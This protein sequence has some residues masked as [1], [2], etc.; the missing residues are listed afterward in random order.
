MT[1]FEAV[2]LGVIQGL[3]E[4][5]PISS[6]AHLLVLSRIF[7][8]SDPGAAFTAVSQI[9]TEMAV[10]IYFRHDIARILSAWGR[11]LVHP[12]MRSNHD[13]K[14]GWYVIL[15]TIPIVILGLLF[16]EQIET[17]ARNLWLTAGMLAVFGILLGIADKWG[18]KI[19]G[20]DA[21]RTRDAVALGIAQAAALI[22]GVS[23]SGATITVGLALG[24]TREAATRYAFLLAIP[25]V[26][27]SG[28]YEAT[29]IG[30]DSNVAWG[31][32]LVATAIAFVVGYAVIA[33]L[34]RY[35]RTGSYLPF[36]A[37]RIALAA[38]IV[39]LL[40]TGAISAT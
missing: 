3:T 28:A 5:L 8:W 14:L 11:S 19:K 39:V 23:R 25:A 9:G 35:L 17:I 2:V 27:G 15:G 26:L 24:Y 20:I 29:R 37:Y 34:L 10:L 40:A 4:F 7:G 21:L 30:N 36:V 16:T 13:A 33:W 1:W 31:Q 38:F 22:P 18:S 6:S 32:T 12:E